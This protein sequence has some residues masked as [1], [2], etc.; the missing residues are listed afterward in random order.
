MRHVSFRLFRSLRL[1]T[2]AHGSSDLQS[3]LMETY[4]KGPTIRSDECDAL[5]EASA[6][7]VYHPSSEGVVYAI[8]SH[9]W[10]SSE[11]SFQN[12]QVL[13]T[14][15][16][17]PSGNPRSHASDKIRNFCIYAEAAG[18]ELAWEDTCCIGKTSSA[19]L[20]EAINSM[21]ARYANADVCFAFLEDVS[22]SDDPEIPDFIFRQSEWFMRGWTLQEPIAPLDVVFLSASRTPLCSKCVSPD[23]VQQ[24]TGID[25]DVLL[26]LVKPQSIP[27]AIYGEGRHAFTRLQEKVMEQSP[28]HTKIVWGLCHSVSIEELLAHALW[29]DYPRRTV[30]GET[31]PTYQMLFAPSPRAFRGSSQVQRSVGPKARLH[32]RD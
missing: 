21:Y 7:L 9:V 26:S 8:L 2:S 22:V 20:S 16:S 28:D 10:S 23:L 24:V 18:C 4:V 15:H 32:C 12:P 27:A 31:D 30:H 3:Y 13:Q 1:L 19:E 5:F 17:S 25:I 6:E 11:Q 29:T 14:L